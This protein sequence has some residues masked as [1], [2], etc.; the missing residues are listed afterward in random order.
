[1]SN[2]RR[3]V[4]PGAWSGACA[5]R[6]IAQANDDLDTIVGDREIRRLAGDRHDAFSVLAGTFRDELLDPQAQ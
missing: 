5:A 3:G 6:L 2:V 1:M 4:S